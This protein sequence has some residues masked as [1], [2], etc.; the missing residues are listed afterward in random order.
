MSSS[1][2]SECESIEIPKLELSPKSTQF[3]SETSDKR[4][5]KQ[6]GSATI[7]FIDEDLLLEQEVSREE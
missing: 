5:M 4:S 7:F 2:L 1:Q 6:P 3:S